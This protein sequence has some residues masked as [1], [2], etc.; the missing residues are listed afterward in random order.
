MI[1]L[2]IVGFVVISSVSFLILIFV[3]MPS[4]GEE[5][6]QKC[7]GRELLSQSGPCGKISLQVPPSCH[8]VSG[9]GQRSF[10]VGPLIMVGSLLPV[11]SI[12]EVGGLQPGSKESS[13]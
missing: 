3:P 1:F 11:P 9:Q 8:G 12:W 7:E 13:P 5:E 6:L 4:N 10:L 2:I